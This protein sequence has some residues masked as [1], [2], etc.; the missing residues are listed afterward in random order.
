LVV[1]NHHVGADSL[2]KLSTRA[3]NYL[4]D[5]Y[6]A[7]TRDREL[8]CPDMELNVLTAITDVTDRVN[9]AV[10]PGMSPAKAASARRAVLN[11]IESEAAKKSGLKPQVVTLYQGGAYHLYLYKRYTD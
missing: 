10:K 2:Q 1:T 3:H 11:D 4:R 5:G 8:R 6:L 9:S 7:R